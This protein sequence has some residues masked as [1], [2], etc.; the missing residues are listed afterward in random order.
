MIALASNIFN[1]AAGIN[2]HLPRTEIFLNTTIALA[3]HH[4]TGI[5]SH[6]AK[7]NSIV[8]NSRKKVEKEMHFRRQI[9]K[10]IIISVP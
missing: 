1:A 10:G 7:N 9:V 8:R 5:L 2:A 6:V 4:R 3:A